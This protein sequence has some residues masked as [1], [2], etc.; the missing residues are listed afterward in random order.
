MTVKAGRLSYLDMARA[1]AILLAMTSHVFQHYGI[2]WSIEPDTYRVVKMLTR[3]GTPTFIVLFGIMMELVYVKY[4]QRSGMGITSRRLLKRSLMCYLC[5]AIIAIAAVLG[6]KIEM[7]QFWRAMVFVDKGRYGEIL[8]Y[9]IFALAVAPG[10]LYCRMRYGL[11]SLLL[12]LTALWLYDLLLTGYL[13]SLM[14]NHY[15]GSLILGVGNLQGPSMLH[16][17]TFVLV[18]MIIGRLITAPRG[19][20]LHR[21]HLWSYVALLVLSAVIFLHEINHSGF[22]YVVDNITTIHREMSKGYRHNNMPVY[23]AYGLLTCG[24]LIGLYKLIHAWKPAL[25]NK[26]V[27][28]FGVESLFAYTVGN[29]LINIMPPVAE[30][31]SLELRLF[32]ALLY[33]VALYLLCWGWH[34]AK[35]YGFRVPFF[36]APRPSSNRTSSNRKVADNPGETVK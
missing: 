8:K 32:Y 1:V 13:E 29:A 24:A 33:M 16:G 19:E 23:Y 11:K 9:Y 31:L 36:G 15:S 7:D 18:G 28:L 25:F 2:W 10:V 34:L 3:T 14:G 30:G 22:I 17:M 5:F 12:M 6:S 35:Q 21:Q 27:T 26:T 20:R 4:I